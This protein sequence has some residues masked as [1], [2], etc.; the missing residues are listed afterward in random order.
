MDEVQTSRRQAAWLSGLT[1]DLHYAVEPGAST[2]IR[3]P[4][5]GPFDERLGYHQLP[6]RVE[7][8]AGQGF[9]VCGPGT[10]VAQDDRAHR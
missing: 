9:G 7:R 1:S 10:H 5:A 2:Q 6:E 4:G 8:L 3:F